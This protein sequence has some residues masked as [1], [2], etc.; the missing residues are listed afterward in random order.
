MKTEKIWP[1]LAEGKVREQGVGE[2][3][4]DEMSQN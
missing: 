1:K 3:E 2:T 4:V